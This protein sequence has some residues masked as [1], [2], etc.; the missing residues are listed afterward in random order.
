MSSHRKRGDSASALLTEMLIV[1]TCGWPFHT[2]AGE[3]PASGGALTP[4]S[5]AADQSAATRQPAAVEAQSLTTREA[6][7][8]NVDWLEEGLERLRPHPDYTAIP[9]RRERIG[10]TLK[11]GEEVQLK[12]RHRP[13]SVHLFWNQ[14]GQEAAYV[15]GQNDGKLLVLASGWRRRLGQLRFDPHSS[16]VMRES[17]YAITETGLQLL[18]ERLLRE[19][20]VDLELKAV[21]S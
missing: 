7:L 21:V 3:R 11:E 20:S 10:G 19:R 4:M 2:V 12:L 14:T 5:G 16:L 6:L 17:H 9:Y 1:V 15:E 8:M 13:F 18:A